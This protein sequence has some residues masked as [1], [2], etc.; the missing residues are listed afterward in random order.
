MKGPQRQEVIG[1]WYAIAAFTAWGLLPLYWKALKAVPTSQILGHRII[2][3]F[4]FL[5]LFNTLKK[6]WPRVK[7]TY[8]HRSNR[9]SSLMSG[10]IIGSNWFI[11]IWGVN[12][13]Q[14][15]EVSMGYYINPLLTVLL[16]ILVLKE[17]LKFWQTISFILAFIGVAYMT[18]QYGRI[19]WIA[20]SLA[21]TFGF[22]GL[23]RKTSRVG[24]L[25]GLTAET[26]ILSPLAIFFLGFKGI[27]GTSAFGQA[28]V[29]IHL[30]L[31]GAG[32][33]TATPLLWFAR[34]ARRISL[35]T[36]GFIQYLSPTLQLL[37]GVFV[38]KEPFTTTHGVSFTLIWVALI[39]YSLSNTRFMKRFQPGIPRASE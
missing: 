2:W 12:S 18:F 30:L 23:I 38:F 32:I 5:A 29:S 34:G 26:A 15:V 22:Y 31:I 36:V 7:S 1:T 9:F 16:G 3:S 28:S 20:L 35:S 37:L 39:I 6:R 11:Y 27:E 13:N 24:S 8:L 10:F 17:R 25:T 21:F 33:A 4:V 14:V 19:P